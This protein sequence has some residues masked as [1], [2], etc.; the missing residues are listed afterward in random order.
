[1]KIFKTFVLTFLSHNLKKQI[2]I[3][4]IIFIFKRIVFSFKK[5][6]VNLP[7]YVTHFLSE[8]LVNRTIFIQVRL[9]SEL[10]KEFLTAKEKF[11]ELY[12]Y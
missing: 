7:P 9:R 8:L 6:G 12:G 1:M 10:F 11:G 5:F 2:S 4:I 3:K